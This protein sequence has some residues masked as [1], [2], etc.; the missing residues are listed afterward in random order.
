MVTDHVGSVDIFN[1][2][3]TRYFTQIK[4]HTDLQAFFRVGFF[5]VEE[6]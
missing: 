4:T 2:T 3:L 1:L 5:V 6:L